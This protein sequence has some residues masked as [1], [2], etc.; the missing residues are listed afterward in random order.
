[1]LGMCPCCHPRVLS[2]Q[3]GVRLV[4]V[5]SFLGMQ[6]QWDG[7]PAGV[8]EEEMKHHL[9]PCQVRAE[10]GMLGVVPLTFPL[11]MRLGLLLCLTD[12]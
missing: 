5:S 10:H 12:E 1:M 11:G 7:P 8:W 4:P 6:S 2:G 3:A 9:A